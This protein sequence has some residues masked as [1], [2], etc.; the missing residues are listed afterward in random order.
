MA[1][2][3]LACRSDNVGITSPPTLPL[4]LGI[5]SDSTSSSSIITTGIGFGSAVFFKCF[6]FLLRKVPF[7][8][9]NVEWCVA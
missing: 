1:R 4:L 2:P 5:I 6:L 7:A 8:V 3:N 9:R